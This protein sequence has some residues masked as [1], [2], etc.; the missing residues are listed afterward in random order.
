[1]KSK[2]SSKASSTSTSPNPQHAA[3]K[4]KDIADKGSTGKC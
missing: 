3:E 2:E 4:H 1:M